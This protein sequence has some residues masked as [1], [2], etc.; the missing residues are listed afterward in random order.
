MTSFSLTINIYDNTETNL[1]NQRGKYIITLSISPNTGSINTAG[2]NTLSEVTAAGEYIFTDLRILSSGDFVLVISSTGMDD[3]TT[4]TLS[5]TNYAYDMEIT[6]TTLT[7]TVSFNFD[8]TVTLTGE[9]EDPFILNCEVSLDNGLDST[10]LSSVASKTISSGEAVF[11]IYFASSG[12]KTITASCPETGTASS[13]TK[14]IDIT[15]LKPRLVFTSFTPVIF[16]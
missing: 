16:I 7:P 8:L 9:D 2:T 5:I 14:T 10:T 4:G 11:T 6:S 15:V 12:L 3:F 1:E 13:L